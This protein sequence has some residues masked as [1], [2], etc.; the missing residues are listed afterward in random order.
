MINQDAGLNWRPGRLYIPITSFNGIVPVLS[1]ASA[2]SQIAG[3]IFPDANNF[4]F[5]KQSATN[6]A[7][8][9]AVTLQTA[10]RSTFASQPTT[11]VLEAVSTAVGLV[12]MRMM[13]DGDS[14]GH[15]QML[16]ADLDLKRPIYFHVWWTSEARAV[17]ARS[18]LWRVRFRPVIPGESVAAS[19]ATALSTAILAHAPSGT[20]LAIERTGAVSRGVIVGSTIPH[21]SAGIMLTVD[22]Q[23]ISSFTE[24]KHLLGLEMAYTP[25]RFVGVDGMRH[26]AKPATAMLSDHYDN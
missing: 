24:Y 3:G 14:V 23:T 1:A 2:A 6:Y 26:E 13:N 4:S 15:F 20:Y 22:S 18:L 17:G 19:A 21:S 12:G 9:S 25:K 5:G 11:M 10:G 16:P 7:S 8:S